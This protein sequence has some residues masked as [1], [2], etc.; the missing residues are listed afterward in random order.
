MEALGKFKIIKHKPK[1]DIVYPLI[2]LPQSYAHLAGEDA[3]IFKT[4]HN[5]K[6]L[7]VVSLD[8]DFEG[9]VEVV[10]QS[11]LESRLETLEN[12]MILVIKSL[13]KECGGPAEVRTP[14]PRRVKAMS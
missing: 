12:K 8:A 4:E 10:Q 14:D 6:P 5:G 1:Q 3:H 13:A 2:R 7:F 9:N 11:D